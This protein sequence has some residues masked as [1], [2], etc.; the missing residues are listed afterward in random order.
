MNYSSIGVR[1]HVVECF[2]VSGE[3]TLHVHDKLK[4]CDGPDEVDWLGPDRDIAKAISARL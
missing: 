2:I 1:L 3:I 4:W